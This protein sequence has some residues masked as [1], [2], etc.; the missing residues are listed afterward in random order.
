MDLRRWHET[1]AAEFAM[2][3]RTNPILSEF[4][5]GRGMAARRSVQRRSRGDPGGGQHER[6]AVALLQQVCSW[7]PD[8][9]TADWSEVE[10]GCLG[11]GGDPATG[12]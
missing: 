12:Q 4:H 8:Q 9:L 2:T 11:S 6:A 10:S 3:V 1:V 7:K 5:S